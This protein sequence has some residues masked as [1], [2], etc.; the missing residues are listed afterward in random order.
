VKV[1]LPGSNWEERS[2][3]SVP[4]RERAKAVIDEPMASGKG[5]EQS[6]KRCC[7][8]HLQILPRVSQ[9]IGLPRSTS[10]SARRWRE[11]TGRL[12]QERKSLPRD[13]CPGQDCDA[14]L[15]AYG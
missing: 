12:A 1:D 7:R 13:I 10:A 6:T 9:P 11:A 5:R 8:C 14:V 4:S 15:G 2:R 3:H